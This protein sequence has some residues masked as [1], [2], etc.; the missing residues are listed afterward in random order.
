MKFLTTLFFTLLITN[1]QA[2]TITLD[3]A[4][5]WVLNPPHSDRCT[6]GIGSYKSDNPKAQAMIMATLEHGMK[7]ETEVYAN[8]KLIKSSKIRQQSSTA[9]L[10]SRT[11]S[12]SLRTQKMWRNSQGDTFVLN[13]ESGHNRLKPFLLVLKHYMEFSEYDNRTDSRRYFEVLV[14]KQQLL[15]NEKIDKKARAE[16]AVKHPK[17]IDT[18]P[19]GESSVGMAKI[20]DDNIATAYL[21]ALLGARVDLAK[22]LGVKVSKKVSANPDHPEHSEKSIDQITSQK[23]HGSSVKGVWL[24][25]GSQTLYVLLAMDKRYTLDKN[26]KDATLWQQFQAQ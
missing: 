10:I 22:M 16:L 19:E 14:G 24:D 1:L 2:E 9:K 8:D 3:G 18:L 25:S 7:Y 15:K 5:Q 23:I 13:C 11:L 21:E 6:L 12:K 26:L 20:F 17:W 4:P